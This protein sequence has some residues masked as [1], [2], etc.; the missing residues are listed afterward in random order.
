[1]RLG[2]GCRAREYSDFQ[3]TELLFTYVGKTAIERKQAMTIK[4]STLQYVESSCYRWTLLEYVRPSEQQP[5]EKCEGCGGAVNSDDLQ[6]TVLRSKRSRRPAPI[7]RLFRRLPP[8][9][10][11]STGQ[12]TVIIG[13]SF[14]RCTRFK[15]R[16]YNSY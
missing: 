16:V 11:P 15:S 1:M 14:V 10:G 9:C 8:S 5:Q 13:N 2:H 3:V 6:G 4:F 12:G 7:L